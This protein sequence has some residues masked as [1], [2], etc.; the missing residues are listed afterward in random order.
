MT[1]LDASRQ[2]LYPDD[3][4]VWLHKNGCHEEGCWVRID[5]LDDENHVLFG[6]LL[7]EPDQDF[8]CHEGDRI[9][10]SA[11]QRKNCQFVLYADRNQTNNVPPLQPIP[12][13]TLEEAIHAYYGKPSMENAEAVLQI[14]C[15]ST[16]L[17]PC[18]TKLSVADQ[19][20]FLELL[21]REGETLKGETV[22][23]RD[24]IRLVPDIFQK[25]GEYFFPVFS[26]ETAMVGDYGKQFSIVEKPFPDI[27]P[28][29]QHH[30][31]ELSG[32]VVNP[33]TEPFVV[34][35]ELVDRMEDQ[36]N[37]EEQ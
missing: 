23:S 12:D 17:I 11:H 32:I 4:L 35:V 14:L 21:E 26:A 27:L 1:F 30:P 16:V 20:A 15:S 29:V 31:K 7:N 19:E 36:S 37:R 25:D 10:F 24:P 33:L 3:V 8:G 34:P 6:T 5:A 2:P 18:E 22:V 9:P 13:I 28:V